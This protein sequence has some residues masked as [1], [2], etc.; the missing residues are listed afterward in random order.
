MP[1]FE[2]ECGCGGELEMI[3]EIGSD[4]P[5]CPK[6][7]GIMN[8]K[9]SPPAIIVI[10]NEGGYL[11]KSK[12]YKDGYKKEYLKSKNQEVWRDGIISPKA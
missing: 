3:Q 1:I 4:A 12:G 2:F 11:I 5:A 8:K 7:G 10:K 6:C 9:F